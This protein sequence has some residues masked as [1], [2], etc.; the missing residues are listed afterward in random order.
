MN[1]NGLVLAA[2]A[3][4]TTLVHAE[5]YLSPTEERVRLSLGVAHLS[6]DTNLQLDSSAGVTGTAVNAEDVFGLDIAELERRRHQARDSATAWTS[7]AS[8]V[9]APPRIR[10]AV[11]RSSEASSSRSSRKYHGVFPRA[12]L[13]WRKARSPASGWAA[14][15]NHSSITGSNVRWMAARRDTP[16]VSA[17]M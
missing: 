7:L 1:K 10:S 13:T 17:S 8:V 4:C 12:S 6:N 2:L 16:E 3:L 15:A 5:D 9:L 14:L 11:S